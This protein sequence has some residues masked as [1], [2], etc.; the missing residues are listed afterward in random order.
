MG[1]GSDQ[2]GSGTA[3]N[4]WDPGLHIWIRQ[5]GNLLSAAVP[6]S[7]DSPRHAAPLSCSLPVPP[8]GGLACPLLRSHHQGGGLQWPLPHSSCRALEPAGPSGSWVTYLGS[9]TSDLQLG[10]A[11]LGAILVD[12]LAG[13]E[14]SVSVLRC[15]DV[16]CEESPHSLCLLRMVPAAILHWLPVSQPAPDRSRA[17]WSY[18]TLHTQPGCPQKN[19][20]PTLPAQD[21]SSMLTIPKWRGHCA[22]PLLFCPA[23]TPERSRTHQ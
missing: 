11:L 2:W 23:V 8:Q 19:P 3:G 1:S 16:Q 12:G 18:L 5:Q 14:A 21:E 4:R 13:V 15:Q 6:A 22:C 10:L 9:F 7:A 20:S 17:A